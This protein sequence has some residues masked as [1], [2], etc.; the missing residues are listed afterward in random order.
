VQFGVLGSTLFIL[1]V[2]RTP[3]KEKKAKE[4]EEERK[5]LFCSLCISLVSGAAL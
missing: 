4:K 1:S 3:K 5:G 2:L